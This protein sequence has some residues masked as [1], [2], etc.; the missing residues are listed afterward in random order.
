MSKFETKFEEEID[1]ILTFIKEKT[2]NVVP[3]I[4]WNGNETM[5]AALILQYH[6]EN[7]E[8]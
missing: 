5:V 7:D 8:S 6:K 2:K 4:D 3:P 1:P